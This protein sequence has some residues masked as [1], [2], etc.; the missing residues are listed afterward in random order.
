MSVSFKI[1][2]KEVHRLHLPEAGK[3]AEI[4]Q[5]TRFVN[6]LAFEVKS[7]W[8]K[9]PPTTRDELA[10]LA[11]MDPSQTPSMG[12]FERVRRFRNGLR[13]SRVLRK[14]PEVIREFL[15]AINQLNQ[16]V[17]DAIERENPEYQ[18]ALA[19]A[20]EEALSDTNRRAMDAEQARERNQELFDRIFE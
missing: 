14:D 3:A 19:E 10:K 18:E 13:L 17:L 2:P 9:I 1:T 15:N 5:R 6:N 4:A 16:A 20:V 8:K 11:Y 12:L 7:S